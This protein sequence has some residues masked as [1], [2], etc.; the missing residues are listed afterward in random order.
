MKFSL[1]WLQKLVNITANPDQL[2]AQLTDAGLEV[3]SFENGDFD[4]TV[5]F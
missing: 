4:Y 3:E 2:S 5:Q 1:Q